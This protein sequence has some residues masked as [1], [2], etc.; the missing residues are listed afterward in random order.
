VQP[1]KAK[2]YIERRL[3]KELPEHLT[4]HSSEHTHDVYTAAARIAR[5][6]GVSGADLQ[7]L[8]TAAMYH[9]CGMI[10][11]MHGHETI[12]CDIARKHL[13]EFGYTDEQIEAICSMI[14]ATH[15]PQSPK[16]H[17][18]EILCDADL[19]YLGR[20]DVLIISN[21]LFNELKLHGGTHNLNEW[22]KQQV[23]FLQQHQ[24]FTQT[25]KETRQPKKDAYLHWIQQ[26]IK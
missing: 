14:M 19:D 3:A 9:D 22:N 16:N 15:I 4:Y 8:L 26:Q 23:T 11:K 6:E 1:D 17:L 21:H 5:A 25:S 20:E 2:A 12:S 10:V 18:E 24:Y 7:L 13:P